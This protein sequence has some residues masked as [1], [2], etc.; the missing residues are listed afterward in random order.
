[1]R[2]LSFAIVTRQWVSS[3]GCTS[4]SSWAHRGT[5]RPGPQRRRVLWNR[6]ACGPFSAVISF[7]SVFGTSGVRLGCRTRVWEV[8]SCSW[9]RPAARPHCRG[10]DVPDVLA[11][12]LSMDMEA[13]MVAGRIL[14]YKGFIKGRV[15]EARSL[16]VEESLRS[17]GGHVALRRLFSNCPPQRAS[18]S[19][20]SRDMGVRG[21]PRPAPQMWPFPLSSP[22]SSPPSSSSSPFLL[23]VWQTRN[24][25]LLCPVLPDDEG[26]C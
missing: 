7:L 17:E 8:P 18:E 24:G 25:S 23:S 16:D 11:A 4:A 2:F 1:M 15:S 20:S 9:G 26:R 10:V 21:S 12:P 14:V 19:P 22:S 6:A 13:P 5:A 3:L